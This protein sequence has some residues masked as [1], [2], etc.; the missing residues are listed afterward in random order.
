MNT[1]PKLD[2]FLHQ[3]N[4]NLGLICLKPIYIYVL[5]SLFAFL[6]YNY[7]T[8]KLQVTQTSQATTQ[9]QQ[10]QTSQATT[11]LQ[12]TQTSQAT[13]LKTNTTTEDTITRILS[14]LI[15]AVI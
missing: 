2:I 15:I 7:I 10:A 3:V 1:N 8:Y 4:E 14:G 6:F 11:Q 13:Q 9:L 5:L 12:P